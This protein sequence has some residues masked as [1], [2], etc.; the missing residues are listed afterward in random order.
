MNGGCD[1]CV[2]EGEAVA[3]VPAGWLITKSKPVKRLVEELATSV[4]GENSAGAIGP[5]SSRSEP[6][7]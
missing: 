5:V 6:Q 3:P 4:S 2:E 7:D 1:I